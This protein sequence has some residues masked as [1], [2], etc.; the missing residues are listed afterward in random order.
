MNKATTRSVAGRPSQS[1]AIQ[2]R[3]AIIKIHPVRTKISAT[4]EKI[5]METT[6]ASASLASN[7]ASS[8][9][10]VPALRALAMSDRACRTRRKTQ[11]SMLSD[12]TISPST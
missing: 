12:M 2:T 6:L 10:S 7:L 8:T 9:M 3:A 4:I 11:E 1:S 5:T